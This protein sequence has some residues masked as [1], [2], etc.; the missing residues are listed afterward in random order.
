MKEFKI[1]NLKESM[2]RPESITA[3]GYFIESYGRFV[4]YDTNLSSIFTRL[5]QEAGRWC[6]SYASDILIDID[7]IK[8]QAERGEPGRFV[9]GFRQFGVDHA[10]FIES[11]LKNDPYGKEYR[12]IWVVDIEIDGKTETVRL[13]KT[14]I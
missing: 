12:A 5:I 11:R 13:F 14:Q 3:T 9:L 4:R 10:T 7:S 8:A 2:Y 1:E 6:E